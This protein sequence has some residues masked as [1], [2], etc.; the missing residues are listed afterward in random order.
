MGGRILKKKYVIIFIICI[1]LFT[2]ISAIGFKVN[3]QV[4][5]KSGLI[6]LNKTI[7]VPD[8]YPTIQEAIDSANNGD[9][10]FV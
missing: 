3:T 8:D 4:D 2:N 5:N 7:I 6:L 10:V 1:F 9:T